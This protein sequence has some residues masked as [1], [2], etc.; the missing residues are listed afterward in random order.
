MIF[1]EKKD[2]KG[3]IVANNLNE[4][5]FSFDKLKKRS[6]FTDTGSLDILTDDKDLL[7]SN[8]LF[9]RVGEACS[10]YF[11]CLSRYFL[12][13][14]T[15]HSH[16]LKKIQGQLNQKID[17]IMP[18]MLSQLHSYSEQ[19]NL[20]LDVI[21]N[22]PEQVSIALIYIQKR[23]FELGSHM[24]SFEIVHAGE[25]LSLDIRPHEMG[26]M[27]L[28]IW[29]AFSDIMEERQIKCRLMFDQDFSEKNKV[30]LDYKTIN[31]AF[32]N[33]FD[34]ISK[35][36]KPCSEVRFYLN[37]EESNNF[38]LIITMKSLRIE[39]NE[40]SDIFNLGYRGKNC[41]SNDGSGVGMYVF[42]KALDLNNLNIE[43]NPDYSEMEKYDECQYILNK[44]IIM[45]KTI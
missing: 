5:T 39:Q 29:H 1:F 31:T 45:G 22:N 12:D 38:K 26:R 30:K 28:N 19:K 10:L 43:I 40:I 3:K 9:K 15:A 13:E 24:S 41:F 14:N 36:A 25:R 37:I 17:G 20:V 27:L 44:F 42:K 8:K 21:K 7:E 32:Y 11:D 18:P 23:I 33:F 2:V 6:F 34:N 4:S 16:T 35:Y